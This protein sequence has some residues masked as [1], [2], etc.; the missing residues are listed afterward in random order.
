[1]RAEEKRYARLLSHQHLYLQHMT[2][3]DY[4]SLLNLAAQRLVFYDPMFDSDTTFAES[5][6]SA[7]DEVVATIEHYIPGFFR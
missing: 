6:P 3:A 1:M 2:W 4:R 5:Y 7:Y